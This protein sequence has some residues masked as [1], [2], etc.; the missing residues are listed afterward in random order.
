M[1]NGGRSPRPGGVSTP[2]PLGRGGRP[3]PDGGEKFA[4]P[5]SEGG[6]KFG[7]TDWPE[8]GE[9]VESE[10]EMAPEPE[11]SGDADELP[12]GENVESCRG[13]GLGTT[14]DANFCAG[15]TAGA[16]R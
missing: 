14:A 1:S 3:D 5:D 10:R 13:F 7:K 8:G 11:E 16:K 9:K 4:C 12:G 15:G 6:K 2:P